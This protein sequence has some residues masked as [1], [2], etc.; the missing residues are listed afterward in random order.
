MENLQDARTLKLVDF[1]TFGCATWP[2]VLSNEMLRILVGW[3]KGSMTRQCW[4]LSNPQGSIMFMTELKCDN[5]QSHLFHSQAQSK[6]RENKYQRHQA[7]F[8]Y[9]WAWEFLCMFVVL[10][11]LAC[12]TYCLLWES[13]LEVL[14]EVVCKHLGLCLINLPLCTWTL[15]FLLE[16]TFI[17]SLKLVW[18]P[19]IDRLIQMALC[20]DIK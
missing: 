1:P 15:I 17:L 3:H 10:N 4:R 14:I 2:D 18:Y 8:K 20:G 16:F 9:F 19:A 6:Y 5:S 7:Y 11:Y 13:V 12:C